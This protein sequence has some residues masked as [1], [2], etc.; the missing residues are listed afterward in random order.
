[1]PP[2]YLVNWHRYF[3][4]KMQHGLS[5]NVPKSY[6]DKLLIIDPQKYS[7]HDD[8]PL[9]QLEEITACRKLLNSKSFHGGIRVLFKY[10][11]SILYC[12][13]LEYQF[14]I[15]I[16]I[17]AITRWDIN[18]V[19]GLPVFPSLTAISAIG[20]L[21]SFL[22]VFF[23]SQVYSRYMT[24]YGLSMALEG[25]IFDSIMLAR[26]S[27]PLYAAM[28][29]YRHLNA[30]HIL[31]YTGFTSAY[32]PNNILRPLNERHGLLTEEEMD[33][34]S[35]IGFGGGSTSRE[36]IV[37]A[38]E[39][40][41]QQLDTGCITETEKV[42]LVDQLLRFRSAIG[43]LFDYADLPFPFV[44]VN[45]VYLVS[46]IY[47][48][49]F[50]FALGLSFKTDVIHFEHELVGILCVVINTLFIV[51]VR[52]IAQHMHD[53]FGNYLEDLNVL[54]YLNF[55]IQASAKLLFTRTVGP[56]DEALERQLYAQRPS[57]GPA[58]FHG[59][60]KYRFMETATGSEGSFKT[61]TADI[62]P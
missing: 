22:L 3:N 57:L 62:T 32:K 4:K 33:R 21:V 1:M 18:Y 38:I 20:G 42:A 58:Y 50:A 51:G 60:Q 40:V 17:Y 56:V 6:K 8:L 5:F 30:A 55:T 35:L 39:G 24:L 26:T 53:P 36:V 25:R 27:L 14:W 2:S 46:L 11:G 28:R 44:Y 23:I 48:A 41:Q 61:S 37:W 7:K 12:V 54:H 47:P 10:E 45:F 19:H 43:S 13:L 31:C 49:L 52:R 16:I 15:G 59:S 29:L 34:L 9:P